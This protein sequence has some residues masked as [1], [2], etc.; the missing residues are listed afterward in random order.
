MP[1]RLSNTAAVVVSYT[2][3]EECKAMAKAVFAGS[4]VV[5]TRSLPETTP[6]DAISSFDQDAQAFAIGGP[7]TVIE[8]VV[9]IEPTAPQRQAAA[10]G[11]DSNLAQGCD[12]LPKTDFGASLPRGTP[13]S[14]KPTKLKRPTNLKELK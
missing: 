2:T 12:E 8:G 13:V 5:R 6:P 14:R 3:V 11:K 10:Q 7:A 1:C 9:D 4:R